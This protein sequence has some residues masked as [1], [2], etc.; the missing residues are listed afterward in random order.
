[1][2][3]FSLGGK[4]YGIDIMKVKEIA[5]Y[6][7]FTYVPN[8]PPFVRGVYNLRGEIISVIDLRKM[9]NLPVDS[10]EGQQSENGL[11]LRLEKNLIGIIVD[12]IDK[13]V[14]I[15]KESIQPPHPIFADV[16][17]QYISGVVEHDDRLYIIL[18]AERVFAQDIE[19]PVQS[20]AAMAEESEAIETLAPVATAAAESADLTLSFIIE[21][22]STFASFH[23]SNLNREW[24]ENRFAQWHDTHGGQPEGNQLTSVDDA[25]AYLSTFYSPMN[26]RFWD[27]SYAEK[28]IGLLP[29]SSKGGLSVWNPGCGKG[30]ETYSLACA[31][32]R[33][34]PQ[35]RFKIWASDRDL[36]NIS[37][38]PNLIFNQELL[39]EEWRQFTVSGKNG[40]SFRQELKDLI[41]F[42]YHDI[43]HQNS[44]P[45]VDVVMARD[46]ISFL[47]PE[48]Q[49][50]AIE[51]FH[52]HLKDNGLLILG[53]N[54]R[55][56]QSDRWRPVG[57]NSMSAYQKI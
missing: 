30:Y 14:G 21:T 50:K 56:T 12:S 22:L 38:A 36:L 52:D 10:N 53:S 17:I 11:I 39:P 26:N 27:R 49:Q 43:T 51:D 35:T 20:V 41:L 3:T 34:F 19:R 47:K 54:E 25:Q 1:M 13:V 42:E 2:V 4:D 57:D 6:T 8:C 55:L 33:L 15:S 24:V 9:F 40:Y 28:V 23:V 18:D 37:T 29:D 46:L 5:K 31:Y 7:H 45:D 16:N 44:L 32:R 48:D